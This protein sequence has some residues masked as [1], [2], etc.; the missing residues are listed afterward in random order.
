MTEK[1]YADTRNINNKIDPQ[2]KHRLE[3]DQQENYWRV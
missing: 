1:R 3:N 2:K